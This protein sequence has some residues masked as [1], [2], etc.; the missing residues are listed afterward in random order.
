MNDF[1]GVEDVAKCVH[2]AIIDCFAQTTELVAEFKGQLNAQVPR[3][4]VLREKKSE[5]PG[6]TILL[7]I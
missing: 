6:L 3:L 1:S 2:P 5:D 7:S 4:R